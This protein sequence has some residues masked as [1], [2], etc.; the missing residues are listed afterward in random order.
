VRYEIR[1]LGVGGILDQAIAVTKDHFWLFAKI[2]VIVYVPAD[3]ADRW[4]FSSAAAASRA[5]E[6]AR[7]IWV[8]V[9]GGWLVKLFVVSPIAGSAM[10][11]AVA[12]SYLSRP[13]SVGTAFRRARTVFLQLF[14]TVVLLAL[15]EALG[16]MLLVVPFFIFEFWYLLTAQAVVLEGLSGRAA[17]SRSRQ[18]MKGNTGNAI[19]IIALLLAIRFGAIA[20][21][22][23]FIPHTEARL[24]LH[25]V[26]HAI[27]FIFSRTAW[28]V[29]YFSC[30][31]KAE[32]FD[33][34]LLADAVG[35]D[36]DQPPEMLNVSPGQAG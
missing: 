22:R 28:V 33:L 20:G 3:L 35:I 36:D 8:A 32:H 18:L 4:L 16:L 34:A 1:E 23:R 24:I 5:G 30:R 19:I 15:I 29:F 6:G 31:V 12:S 9:A 26:I 21:V 17:L 25:S 2:V 10:I 27:L 14:G 11:Y 7:L 13:I